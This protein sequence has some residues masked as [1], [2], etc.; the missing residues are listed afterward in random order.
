MNV[1]VRNVITSMRLMSA[2]DWAELFERV[3]LVDEV[4][5]AESDFAAMDFVTRDRYRHAIEDLARG[6][7]HAELEVARRAVLAAKRARAASGSG[8]DGTTHREQDPGYYL[9]ARGRRAF[10]KDLG[11]RLPMKEWMA[12]VYRAT[13][14]LGYLGTIALITALVLA[15]SWQIMDRAGVE[16]SALW[17]LALLAVIPASDAAVA[18]AN[19]YVT[20]QFQPAVL[21]GLELR[22]GVP[23]SLRTMVAVP[24]LLTTRAAIEEQLERLEVH[25]LA[26][27]DDDLYFALLSD[28]MDS[29]TESAPG[30]EEL[31]SAA[32]EGIARLN[33]RYRP[34]PDG[35]RFLLLHRRRVWNEGEGKWMGWER[36]RG[37]L[38]EL[39]G[40]LRGAT[41]TT[42]IAAG[43]RSPT[44]PAGVRYVITLDADTQL[45][46]GATRR[47]VGKMAHPLNR[48]R[49]DLRAGRV[50]EGYAILQPRVTPMLP[51]GREGSLLQRVLSGPAGLDPYA[52]AVSDVYQD[53]F[54]EGSY[55][56]K[57]IYDVDVF[58]T[59]L[60]GKAPENTLLSHD[61]F[62]GIFAR[63]G[64]A[65]DIEVVE[66]FP[67]RY[68]VAAARQHRWAR[69]DWQLLPWILGRGPAIPLIGRWKML[70]NL[71]RTLAAPTT[72][73]ALLVGWTLPFVAAAIWTGLVAA[74]LALPALLPL[75]SGIVPRR[76][77]ISKRSHFGAKGED[78]TL[79]LSRVTL[80]VTFLA[81][82][83]W[84]M[85]DAIV[86]TLF[87]VFVSR[88]RLLEW[89][90]AA[91]AK[92]GLRLDVGGFY[93]RMAGGVAL[94]S[95]AAVCVVCFGH[96]AGPIAA[97][98]VVLWIAS[99]VVA[100]WASRPP[101]AAGPA[102][103]A[104]DALALRLVARRTWRFF[105]T[106]VTADD[107][108]LPPDNF[109]EVPKP[110]VAH[111]TS[112]TNLGLYLLSAV[113]AHDFGWMGMLETVE[114]LEATL[115]T[116]NGLERF[117][118]HF[119]N[120]YDTQ[121]LRPLDPKYV[122]SV[123][124]GNLAGHLIAVGNA[125]REMLGRPVIGPQWL[126]GIG[127]ALAL[128]RES[129]RVL[130]D[131]R[132]A[133]NGDAEAVERC[134][135]RARNLARGRSRHPRGRRRNNGGCRAVRRHRRR[136]R[137][138][139]RR[140]TRRR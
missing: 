66:E 98:F 35:D 46:R 93:R 99:P 82:Q 96:G 78:L 88:R 79:A 29:G 59:A 132:R 101:P 16:S 61:L 103:T 4:L 25:H 140:G 14:I 17:L 26:S 53:L 81:H 84:L 24:T 109:Q 89:V 107:H 111:R 129:L 62:E 27:P 7:G 90:T 37:K 20:N 9:I 92:G 58:E 72:F 71:R 121:D 65:S 117:R 85:T 55:T 48:P 87:R 36:K 133:Q 131:D 137:A 42:F 31:L 68:D 38:H 49:L 19:R 77:G 40:L 33:R 102:S 113:A 119:Y 76:L 54:E 39:N 125:C 75:F 60:A 80:L 67:S 12:R 97:P 128:T 130:A 74:L 2:V 70:D 127:D 69:G 3:S 114:R 64:L 47:L 95:V 52:L 13:G 11:F 126:A 105:E 28:W 106:F 15:A 50:V 44:V 115:A 139:S 43:G 22:D 134:A 91:Q 41:D 104:V 112:P 136:H 5:R 135:R 138:N 73:L 45:P 51:M 108:W 122:S 100:L 86:R 63:A 83:A 21:P 118:G 110:T 30:D 34:A 56:G 10:E 23:T 1:T 116:M 123:D 32:A 8:G 6:S 18:L 124:S 120:W 57:G 94:A